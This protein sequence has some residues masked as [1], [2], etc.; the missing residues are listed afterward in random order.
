MRAANKEKCESV[1][2]I[3]SEVEAVVRKMNLGETVQ[4]GADELKDA[5][6][7]G[8][9]GGRQGESGTERVSSESWRASKQQGFTYLVLTLL[10]LLVWSGAKVK[11]KIR[12]PWRVSCALSMSSSSVVFFHG[13]GCLAV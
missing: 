1:P 7:A 3:E 8:Q 2:E 9:N 11:S 12:S 13:L 6:V 5:T 10:R 4:R